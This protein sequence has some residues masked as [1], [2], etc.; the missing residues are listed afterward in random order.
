ME[1]K[2][3]VQGPVAES[4]HEDPGRGEPEA[5]QAQGRAVGAE[6]RA[7]ARGPY[8]EERDRAEANGDEVDDE[9]TL[10]PAHRA[11]RRP[12]DA[13]DRVRREDAAQ[14]AEFL[15]GEPL[16]DAEGDAHPEAAGADA[17]NDSRGE[18]GGERVA[19]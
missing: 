8:G 10:D 12:G 15:A 3:P 19:E 1:R 11:H 17:L 4:D 5:G 9:G 6:L 18:V 14:T 7:L 2:R 16:E 13:A